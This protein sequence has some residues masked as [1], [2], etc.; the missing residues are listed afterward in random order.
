MFLVPILNRIYFFSKNLSRLLLFLPSLRAALRVNQVVFGKEAGGGLC[1][2]PAELGMYGCGRKRR[3]AAAPTSGAYT[4]LVEREPR[5]P[6]RE[7]PALWGDR[8]GRRLAPP[9]AT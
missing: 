8:W 5:P 3:P 1:M 7:L 9:H 4:S 6:S 2:Y